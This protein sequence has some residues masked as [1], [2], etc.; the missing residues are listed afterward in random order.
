MTD[1]RG[2]GETVNDGTSVG[3]GRG[4]EMEGGVDREC[5]WK[6]PEGSGRDDGGRRESGA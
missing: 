5:H 3:G 2:M 6:S 1:G 4:T